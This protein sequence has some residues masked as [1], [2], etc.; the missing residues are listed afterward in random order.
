MKIGILYPRSKAHPGITADFVDGIKATLQHQLNDQKI[1]LI[2][3]S[4]SFGGEEKEVYEKAEKLLLLEGADV[5]VAFIDLRIL[6]IIKP[7][8]FASGK[9][10]MVIN[11]GANY[12]ENWVPQP[13]IVNLTLQHGF[14]CWLTGK[15][16]AQANKKNAATATTFYDCGYLHTAAMV[17]GFVNEG[18]NITYNYVNNQRYDDS[19]EIKPLTDFLSK[20]KTTDCLLCVFDSFPASLF[21]SRLNTYEEAGN[22]NLF[23]SP[24]MLEQ[25][26]LENTAEGFKFSFNGY[27]P[28]HAAIETNANR[29]FMDGYQQQ[30]KRVATVFSLLG[31]ETGL[32]LQEVFLRCNENY[33]D[34]TEIAGKLAAATINSPRGEMRLDTETNYFIAPVYACAVD[35]SKGNRSIIKRENK[36]SEWKAFT[37]IPT[38]GVSSG[39]TNT[40]LCY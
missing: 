26:A 39:W 23:V 34:G 9:L 4:I 38:E 21:Y 19:F 17:K 15:M 22:L 25:A 14:L 3:E 37:E 1:Q 31:W 32:I 12:P 16:A 6:E 2:S 20:D 28:W 10:V 30:A 35:K 40:Y 29:V 18:G 11:P 27:L 7:L 24:M 13:N 8:L 36:E 33:S 5:L